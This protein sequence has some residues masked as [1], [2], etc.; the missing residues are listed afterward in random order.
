MNEKIA[1]VVLSCDKYSDLWP[2]YI[3]CFQKFWPE[4]PYDKYFVSNC[5]EVDST[6][7]K[8]ILIGEDETWSIGL[9]KVLDSLRDNYKYIFITLE[10]LYL[11]KAVNNS[12]V[13]ATIQSFVEADGTYL[14]VNTHKR[15]PD[16]P[17]NEY[18]GKIKQDAIYRNNCVYAVWNIEKLYDLLRD[19]E[20]A[21]EFERVGVERTRVSE[22][23]YIANKELIYP[24]NLVVKGKM[25]RKEWKVVKKC[26][27][28]AVPSRQFMPRFD[29]F[30][31]QTKRD[32]IGIF[33]NFPLLE[34]LS[35]KI[36]RR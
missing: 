8:S 4:C 26:F 34:K 24:L 30:C 23:Y 10:D 12:M 27:P 13:T 3:R 20:N 6:E 33:Y 9:K 19:N 25:L 2:L 29:E 31:L 16:L 36:N 17:F 7:F 32:L 5:K 18:F 21:W 11:Y 22:D 35:V 1:F 14:R 15:K 28:E